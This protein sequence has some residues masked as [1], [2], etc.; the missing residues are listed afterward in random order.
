MFRYQNEPAPPPTGVIEDAL[1][2][3]RVH[4]N[5]DVAYVSETCPDHVAFQHVSGAQAD[6]VIK[7]GLKIPTDHIFCDKIAQGGSPCVV[8]DVADRPEISDLPFIKDAKVA[9]FVVVP[10]RVSAGNHYGTFCC[11]SH[12]PRHDL[13]KRDIAT[14]AMF[15]KLTTQTLN[16]HFEAQHEINMLKNQLVDVIRDDALSIH[17]Q[18]IVSLSDGRP[19]AAEALSRFSVRAGLGPEWWFDQAQRTNMQIELEVKA[20]SLALAHLHELPPTAYLSVN[21]SPSTVASPLF[22]ETIRGVPTDRL[23]VELTEREIIVET[24]ELMQA[25]RILREKRIG[26]AIDDV[27]AGYA[28]LHTI[29]SLRPNVLKLDRSLVSQIYACT[30]KQSLTKAMV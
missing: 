25:L 22:M 17:L 13:S 20:I 6:D 5:M 14:I 1:E 27:G 9:S 10:I 11:Y 3:A 29:V 15:A 26:I 28:G 12:V 19:M 2:A 7:A 23:L 24:P 16:Q 21:A 8:E 30:V 18:P 4:L